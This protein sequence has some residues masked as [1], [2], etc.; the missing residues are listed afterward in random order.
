MDTNL[1]RKYHNETESIID[2][3]ESIMGITINRNVYLF[4][5]KGYN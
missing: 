4:K 2:L 1:K 5:R 3:K